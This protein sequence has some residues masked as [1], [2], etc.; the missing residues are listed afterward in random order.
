M[1][2]E[3]SGVLRHQRAIH[4]RAMRQ[5]KARY[6]KPAGK[7]PGRGCL[8]K[9]VLPAQ[10]PFTLLPGRRLVPLG[11]TTTVNAQHPSE[12]KPFQPKRHD[13]L[14]VSEVNESVWLWASAVAFWTMLGGSIR[15]LLPLSC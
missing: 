11:G 6:P 13:S 15:C 1:L 7:H 5:N 8:L 10:G 14:R 2:G 9:A 12:G 3:Q 4:Q